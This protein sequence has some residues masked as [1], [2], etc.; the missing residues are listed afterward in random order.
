MA[1]RLAWDGSKSGLGSAR[2]L[3]WHETEGLFDFPSN[4]LSNLLS[5]KVLDFEMR[6]SEALCPRCHLTYHRALSDCPN[7]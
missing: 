3:D 7:C 4:V 6:P 2:W 1:H 5:P